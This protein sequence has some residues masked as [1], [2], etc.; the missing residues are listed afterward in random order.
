M[1]KPTQLVKYQEISYYECYEQKCTLMII[2]KKWLQCANEHVN[3]RV[4]RKRFLYLLFA[5]LFLNLRK[6]M[7]LFYGR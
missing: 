7:Q 1:N 5:L 2:F 6:E 4:V 3:I